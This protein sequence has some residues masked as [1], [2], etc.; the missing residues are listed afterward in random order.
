MVVALGLAGC[1]ST[2][3]AYNN[4]PQLAHWWIDRYLDLGSEQAPRMRSS[5]EA[6]FAWH[7]QTQL[8]DYAQFLA[9]LRERAVGE[10][11]PAQVC[12]WNTEVRQRLQPAFERA[13]GA[14]VELSAD[15]QP[16]QVAAMARRF[17]R[18]NAD[19][20]KS[21][22]QPDAGRRE[23][24][25]VERTVERAEAL[26][27]TVNPAQRALIGDAVA[28][29]AF[30]PADWLAERERRQREVLQTLRRWI[31]ERPAAEQREADI[32]RLVAEAEASPDP[33]YR[34]RQQA[35]TAFN[36]ELTASLHNAATP[37][38]RSVL[39]GKLQGWEEDLRVLAGRA[40]PIQARAGTPGEPALR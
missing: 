22:L 28:R 27:G 9:G 15:V 2:R 8:Q 33:A 3:L 38:Q 37:A 13:I 14:A 29:S 34:A 10:V 30:D 12:G 5:L 18:S 36:C 25:A 1:S 35:L 6:W 24:A 19:L 17:E 39:V 32:R 23:A 11:T 4:A 7:R 31:A 40:V 26:Y 16:A 20:R 21:R